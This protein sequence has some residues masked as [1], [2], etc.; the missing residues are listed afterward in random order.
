[1]HAEGGYA[2][3]DGLEGTM[4]VLQDSG[5]SAAEATSWLL[6]G[7][8]T[9]EGRPID[10]L[11]QGRKKQVNSYASALAF[12]DF[13]FINKSRKSSNACL[14][15]WSICRLRRWALP[16]SKSWVISSSWSS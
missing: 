15:A 13:L 12:Y 7:D 16:R 10:A 8:D 4:T 3:V 11:R 5:M 2:L 1:M 14:C 9:F 6:E